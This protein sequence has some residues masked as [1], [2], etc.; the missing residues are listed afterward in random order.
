MFALKFK[1]TL[2]PIFSEVMMHTAHFPAVWLFSLS[3]SINV[4]LPLCRTEHCLLG[5]VLDQQCFLM[6]ET[7]QG[8]RQI[9]LYPLFH[10]LFHSLVQWLLT[11]F[12]L[13]SFNVISR[14]VAFRSLLSTGTHA[15]THK[16]WDLLFI[17]YV[18]WRLFTVCGSFFLVGFDST[19]CLLLI[20]CCTFLFL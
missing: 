19:V 4:A 14:L 17:L 18:Q 6:N 3:C 20:S 2:L 15:H 5:G 7:M 16:C 12:A 11:L 9:G 13:S 1:V 8:K 10:C